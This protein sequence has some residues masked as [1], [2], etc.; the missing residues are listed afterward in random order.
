MPTRTHVFEIT[1]VDAPQ[2]L[3]AYAATTIATDHNL[4]VHGNRVFQANYRA[5][6]RVLEFGDLGAAE[7]EEVAHF[8]TAPDSDA[9][10]FVGAWSVYPYLP[11]GN[12]LA[13]DTRGGLFVLK[14]Q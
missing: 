5:G 7:I 12:L 10:G 6:L 2:H 9:R 11:S 13:S 4:Y 8:D 14:P 1:A 3:Y